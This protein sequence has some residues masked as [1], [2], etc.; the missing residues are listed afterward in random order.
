[1]NDEIVGLNQV[2]SKVM[3]LNKEGSLIRSFG[4]EGSQSSQFNEP[5]GID[6][7]EEGQII[8][9]DWWNHQIQ[10]F[11]YDGSFIR[12]FGTCGSSEGQFNHPCSVVVDGDGNLVISDT[13]NH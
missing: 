5:C 6:V 1:M 11:S 9:V 3:V 8:V 13:W 2:E 10:V 12:C 7:D 4:C